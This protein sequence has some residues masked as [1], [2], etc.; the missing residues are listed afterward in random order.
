MNDGMQLHEHDL[1]SDASS[2]LLLELESGP[3]AARRAREWLERLE[4]PLPP[5]AVL[6]AHELVTNSVVHSPAARIWLTVVAVPDGFRVEVVDDGGGRPAPR[7]PQPF[8]TS[9]RGL[10][11]VD[12]LSDDWGVAP[13]HLTHVWF[14]VPAEAGD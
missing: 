4:L 8:E 12:A 6:L 13:R 7:Q 3:D 1:S 2:C 5:E 10:R 11:W 14:Q 9:G